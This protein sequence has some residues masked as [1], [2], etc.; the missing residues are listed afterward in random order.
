VEGVCWYEMMFLL[1]RSSL[2]VHQCE[3][4]CGILETKATAVAC[5]IV[6]FLEVSQ[7]VWDSADN[8]VSGALSFLSTGGRADPSR[9]GNL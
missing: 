7:V 1:L 5:S 9:E 2:S 8:A 4:R 3:L 6:P